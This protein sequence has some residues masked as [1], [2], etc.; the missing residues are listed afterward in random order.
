[1]ASFNFDTWCTATKLTETSV[2][3]LKK[4]DLNTEEALQ[5]LTLMDLENLGLS[6]GQKCVL[7][8]ALK[9][10]QKDVNEIPSPG[11]A[12]GASNPITTRSLARNGGLEEILK[13]IE[14]AGSLDESLLAQDRPTFPQQ[15][16]QH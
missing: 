4:E 7:E 3:I 13:K 12:I 11:D 16:H 6:M 10:W 8:A 1:M 15:N 14:K 9:K 2:D 5:L